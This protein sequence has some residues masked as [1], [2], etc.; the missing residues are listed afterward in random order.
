MGKK[1]SNPQPPKSDTVRRGGI[2]EGFNVN[3]PPPSNVKPPP[4]PPP[5]P[6]PEK[7]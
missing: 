5:P 2:N 1:E 4:P 3:P 6:P 7:E